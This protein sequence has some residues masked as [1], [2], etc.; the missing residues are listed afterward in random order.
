LQVYECETYNPPTVR[1]EAA[2]HRLR[3]F[4]AVMK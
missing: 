2:G 1:P 3:S 4:D